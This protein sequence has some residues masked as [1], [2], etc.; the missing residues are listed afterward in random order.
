MLEI[1]P[2][3]NRLYVRL[4]EA[5]RQGTEVRIRLPHGDF[6]GVPIYL[7]EEFVELL[8]LYV[9][10]AEEEEGCCER[11]IWLI[12]LSEVRTISLSTEYWSQERLEQLLQP[13]EEPSTSELDVE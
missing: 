13:A 9:P 2:K 11:T 8:D 12:K 10:T 7:D 1:N 4:Q 5:F 3:Q 6:M